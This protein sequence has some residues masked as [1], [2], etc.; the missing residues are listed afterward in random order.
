MSYI[1]AVYS[2]DISSLTDRRW[3]PSHRLFKS[4]L[5]P[6]SC[7]H[8]LLP[9]LQNPSVTCCLRTANKFVCLPNRPKNIRPYHMR[10]KTIS[11]PFYFNTSNVTGRHRGLKWKLWAGH[12]CLLVGAESSSCGIAHFLCA[13]RVFEVRPSPSSPRLPLR[14]ILFA[15][16]ACGKNHVLNHS[17]S[18][19][20]SLFDVSG[21]YFCT[22]QFYCSVYCF[23]TYYL[24]RSTVVH[25]IWSYVHYARV[26]DNIIRVIQ[27][28]S[29]IA[30]N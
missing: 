6:A 23:Y 18:H 8:S 24:L 20:L 16:L 11:L 30:R 22:V 5:E 29:D 3:Q 19:S 26:A 25:A 17:L 15:E 1:N 14:Q 7:L 12:F 27:I 13:M 10:Y 4:I 2:A 28:H 9:N 21:T